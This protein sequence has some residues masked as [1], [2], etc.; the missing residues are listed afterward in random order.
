MVMKCFRK[1][2]SKRDYIENTFS[3]IAD[4]LEISTYS[5]NKG[6]YEM[7][8]ERRQLTTIMFIMFWD[9][10]MV[11]LMWNEVWLLVTNWYIRVAERLKE[12][13]SGNLEISGKS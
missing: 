5:D 9:F 12:F 4:K 8:K 1:E 11:E 6:K 10:S 2:Y 7:V 13:F 3:K